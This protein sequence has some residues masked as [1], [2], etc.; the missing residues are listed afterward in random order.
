MLTLFYQS[1]P[2][3]KMIIFFAI[4]YYLGFIVG[5]IVNFVLHK[6]QMFLLDKFFRLLPLAPGELNFLW[7]AD[8][9][10]Y[11]LV[12]FLIFENF[13]PEKIKKIIIEKAIKNF[14]KLRSKLVFKFWEWYWEE[15]S[16]TEALNT[17]EIIK[18]DDNYCFLKQSDLLDYA[19]SE[20]INHFDLSKDFPFK[21][22]IISNDKANIGSV[23]VVKFDHTFTDGLG[24]IGLITGIADNY[25]IDLFPQSTLKKK[26]I[27]DYF[28]MLTTLPYYA[29]YSFYR[30]MVSLSSGKSPF[31][32]TEGKRNSGMP[33]LQVSKLYDF[34]H[35]SKICK[36]LNITFND[37]MMCIFA[38]SC[39]KY[40]HA[41][42]LDIPNFISAAIPISSRKVPKSLNDIHIGNDSTAVGCRLTLISDPKTEAK[43]IHNEFKSH[44]RNIPFITSTKYLTDI[45]MK[46]LPDYLS[47]L[48]IRTASSRIDFT[49]SNVPGPRRSLFYA[50]GRVKE[51]MAFTTPGFFSSFLGVFSYDGTFRCIATF[52]KALGIDAD[53]FM[54]HIQKEIDLIRENIDVKY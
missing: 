33:S 54:N 44:V 50:G 22:I 20:I 7:T 42:K 21:F 29:F 12:T 8:H 9:E 43:I 45:I 46:F 49:I 27:L 53:E 31:K 24:F 35:Y 5:P 17:I 38:S 47:K 25:S 16:E 34:N 28:M 10:R 37:L 36:S 52:D 51:L 26:G 41:H 14:R 18:N 30:N 23:L 48:I 3:F 11:N 4:C 2:L 40:C 19:Y 32:L 15:V 6:L 13:E 39:R 1:I